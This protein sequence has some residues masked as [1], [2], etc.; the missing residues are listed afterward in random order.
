MMCGYGDV[1]IGTV[2]PAHV[3]F[4]FIDDDGPQLLRGIFVRFSSSDCPA[5]LKALIAKY[6]QPDNVARSTEM[7]GLGQDV[8]NEKITWAFSGGY[9]VL[10]RFTTTTSES[11]FAMMTPGVYAREESGPRAARF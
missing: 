4:E 10:D 3:N 11:R 2:E 1:D 8:Q 6:G 9:L 7:N 5:V